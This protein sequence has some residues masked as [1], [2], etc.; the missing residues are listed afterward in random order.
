MLTYIY[1][2]NIAFTTGTVMKKIA[3][4]DLIINSQMASLNSKLMSNIRRNRIS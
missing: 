4:D 1:R 2:T 3:S